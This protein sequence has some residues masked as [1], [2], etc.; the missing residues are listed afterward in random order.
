MR[1]FPI[2]LLTLT[3]LG[4]PAHGRRLAIASWYGPGFHGRRT[5]SGEVFDQNALTAA[6]KSLPFGTRVRIT[7]PVTKRTVLVRINDRGPYIRGR[8]FDLSKGAAE[9]IGLRQHGVGPVEI[10]V[11]H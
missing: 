2:L 9:A 7:H 10:H 6:H 8:E 5:A 3:M 11:F 4:A 1:A